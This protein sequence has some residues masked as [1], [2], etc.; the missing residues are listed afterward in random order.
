MIVEETGIAKGIRRIVGFTR[1]AAIEARQRASALLDRLKALTTMPGGVELSAA[2]K[3]I[4]VE[5]DQSVVSLVDKDQMR[6]LLDS[7]YD[8]IKA[9]HKASLG[10]KV[11]EAAVTAER[12]ALE[13]RSNGVETLVM[14]LDIGADGKVA[15]KIIEKIRGVYPGASVFIASLDEDEEKIGDDSCR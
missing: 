13:A 7:I 4:K 2:Y 15:K 6:L 5:V 3:S 9:H 8:T 12:L 10:T 14:S 11:A 1:K